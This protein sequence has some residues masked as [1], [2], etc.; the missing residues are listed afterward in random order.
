MLRRFSLGSEEALKIKIPTY[1]N[2]YKSGLR[3]I[4]RYVK[5]NVE[6]LTMTSLKEIIY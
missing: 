6:S 2:T 4:G 1:T 5:C 3:D